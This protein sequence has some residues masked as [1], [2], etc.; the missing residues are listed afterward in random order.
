M[1]EKKQDDATTAAVRP[2]DK[3][4]NAGAPIKA[5]KSTVSFLPGAPDNNKQN[6][7]GTY[8]LYSKNPD[9]PNAQQDQSY[10]IVMYADRD[11]AGQLSVEVPA[12]GYYI[13]V[14]VPPGYDWKTNDNMK[15]VIDAARGFSVAPNG[16]VLRNGEPYEP[17]KHKGNGGGGPGTGGPP[18][19]I[20]GKP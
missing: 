18:V 10:D 9:D 11:I 12:A 13:L 16:T 3:V 8:V 7:E 1:S 17:F 20:L 6:Y 19:V 2:I 14:D 4:T 5:K 15:K